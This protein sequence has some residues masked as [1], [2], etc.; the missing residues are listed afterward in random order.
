MRSS[1]RFRC[2]PPLLLLVATVA[3][4]ACEEDAVRTYR[5]ARQSEA[6]PTTSRVAAPMASDPG[7]D[8]DMSNDQAVP[9]R[10]VD[11]DRL[12]VAWE[13]PAGWEQVANPNR[14]RVV[15]FRA[16]AAD[17]SDAS[18]SEPV[19]VAVSSLPGDG[20]GLLANLNRWRGQ[21]GLEPLESADSVESTVTFQSE[22]TRGVL[23]DMT[24]PT[25]GDGP[26]TRML[27]AVVRTPQRTWF[28]K[29][30][31]PAPQL[32][33]HREAMLAFVR[34]FRWRGEDAQ[35]PPSDSAAMS[36]EMPGESTGAAPRWAV[37]DSWHRAANAPPMLT[38]LFHV[39]AGDGS[40][41]ARVSVVPLPGEAGGALANINRWRRQIGLPPIEQVRDAAPETIELADA[42]ATLVDFTGAG[43]DAEAQ[44]TLAAWTQRG[45]ITWFFKMTGS[46][47]AVGAH[48]DGF[49]SF[50]ASVAFGE[51]Q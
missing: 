40:P 6:P 8:S 1:S 43:D 3:L 32:A 5:V 14:F 33:P 21:I 18:T 9:G 31:A 50:L 45:E 26:A 13:L 29:S 2:H 42:R 34:S 38:A 28:V 20:G 27:V 35:A 25:T 47:D 36:A 39:P 49:R 11:P 15:T 24:G 16:S 37:P 30:T 4:S 41:P 46:A 19:E 17:T 51:S 7:A 23:F 48:E 12:P 22:N 44:R 10:Q